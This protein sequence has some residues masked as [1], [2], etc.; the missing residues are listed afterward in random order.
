MV[1][2]KRRTLR[3]QAGQKVSLRS[4]AQRNRDDILAAAVVA[5][6]K[7][8]NASLEGIARAAGVGIGTLYRHYPTRE[9]LLEAAY[10]TEIEK[11]CRVA[12]G[13]LAKHPPDVALARFLDCFIDYM[14]AK[15]GV[16]QAVRAVFAA[17]STSLNESLSKIAAAVAPMI[18]AGKAAGVLRDDVTVEDFIAVKGAVATA[19]PEAAR[20]LAAILIDGLRHRAPTPRPKTKRARRRTPLG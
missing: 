20:R 11:L 14:L 19:R 16:V 1:N 7:D 10:R 9:S 5:F 17:G 2:N 6:T 4:D 13:L 12:P 18:A 8:A 15:R 3:L